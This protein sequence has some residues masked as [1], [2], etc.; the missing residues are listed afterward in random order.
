MGLINRGERSKKYN[1]QRVL[2]LR[3]LS[4]QY[5]FTHDKF[6]KTVFFNY[7]SSH[8]GLFGSWSVI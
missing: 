3:N 5:N 2:Q 8:Q 1:Q 4:N 7:I 6:Y